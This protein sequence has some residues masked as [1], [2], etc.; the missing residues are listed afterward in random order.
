MKSQLCQIF[1]PFPY[2]SFGK[3]TKKYNK[4]QKAQYE[5]GL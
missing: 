4:K 3:Y 1:V 2:K 5:T